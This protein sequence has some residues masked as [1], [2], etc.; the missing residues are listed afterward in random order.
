[1]RKQRF[2]GYLVEKQHRGEPKHGLWEYRLVLKKRNNRDSKRAQPVQ[3]RA[4]DMRLC[5]EILRAIRSKLTPKQRG[6]IDGL[7]QWMGANS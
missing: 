4:E 6:P 5:L 2:G 7:I 1:M 3:F